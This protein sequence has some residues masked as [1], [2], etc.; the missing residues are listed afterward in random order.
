MY[1]YWFVLDLCRFV[2]DL[3]FICID[4]YW[5]RIDL[6]WFV[7]HLYCICIDLYW[8][9]L[10]LYCICNLLLLLYC[11]CIAFVWDFYWFVLICIGFVVLT[12]IA[13]DGIRNVYVI[14][15]V[16]IRI[17]FASRLAVPPSP[18]PST[19]PPSPLRIVLVAQALKHT[20]DAILVKQTHMEH[21]MRV[22]SK[23]AGHWLQHTLLQNRKTFVATMMH[24]EVEFKAAMKHLHAY[25][26]S[27]QNAHRTIVDLQW[28][29]W[30]T[31][32]CS[33]LQHIYWWFYYEQFCF[34]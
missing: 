32:I 17:W 7:L 19:P 18:L 21:R 33:D 15:F 14:R 34:L 26:N 16:W 27:E 2:W 13:F 31:M 29:A 23:D 6:Y 9:V 20:M 1:L 10:H 24:K 11:L 30:F 12:C 4:L 3:Y 25:L 28:F 8:C 5:F 22:S